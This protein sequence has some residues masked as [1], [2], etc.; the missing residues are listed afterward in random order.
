MLKQ[1]FTT[2]IA[3][4]QVQDRNRV[5]LLAWKVVLAQF[6]AID[7]PLPPSWN[8]EL[9]YHIRM[10][11]IKYH[12]NINYHTTVPVNNLFIPGFAMVLFTGDFEEPPDSSHIR[13]R[14]SPTIIYPFDFEDVLNS[15]QLIH[16]TRNQ[17]PT[18]RTSTAF[19][20]MTMR[21]LYA[22]RSLDLAREDDPIHNKLL[23]S[24]IHYFSPNPL[25]NTKDINPN[26][27][28][29]DIDYCS[30]Q[31]PFRDRSFRNLP[32]NPVVPPQ[33]RLDKVIP[34]PMNV[35]DY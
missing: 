23:P 33:L 10:T 17:L 9:R 6:N 32:A 4:Y 12:S 19:K 26:C 20:R 22:R 8:H 5:T 27:L 1:Y 3:D 29:Y 21:D 30:S 34:V 18:T 28:P 11:Y 16:G 35:D 31:T 24:S 15:D 13:P 7:G 25:R 14:L 2:I